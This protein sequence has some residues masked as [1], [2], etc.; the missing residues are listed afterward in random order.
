MSARAFSNDIELAAQAIAAR[1]M[2]AGQ[3]DITKMIADAIQQE[4]ARCVACYDLRWGQ[5]QNTSQ[6]S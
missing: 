2:T 1:H 5:V 6:H 4:R 3:K